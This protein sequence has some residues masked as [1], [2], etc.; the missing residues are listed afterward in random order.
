MAITIVN[1]TTHPANFSVLINGKKVDKL[2]PKETLLVGLPTEP[3]T[4]S[5][6][7]SR[8]KPIQVNN[9]D[10]IILTDHKVNAFLRNKWVYFI[11]FIVWLTLVNLIRK[12]E[13]FN[14]YETIFKTNPFFRIVLPPSNPV[15][16]LTLAQAFTPSFI[17]TKS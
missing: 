7:W 10:V 13:L 15:I 1:Q 6:R 14:D 12:F 17:I 16:W 4:L 5:F 8:T 11:S 2:I 9:D 3:A